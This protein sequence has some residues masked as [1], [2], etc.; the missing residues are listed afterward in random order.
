[1][2]LDHSIDYRSEDFEQRVR[3]IT[4]GR[5][6]DIALDAT[7]AFRK[8]FRC[9]AAAGPLIMLRRQRRDAR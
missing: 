2:G 1:M 9:L 5:G 7:G 6:F 3:E 8:R 4:N